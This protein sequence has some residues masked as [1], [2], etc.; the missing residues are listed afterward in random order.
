MF[1]N[2]CGKRICSH[3]LQLSLDMKYLKNALALRVS[4][5]EYGIGG[6]TLDFSLF[7]LDQQMDF[8]YRLLWVG[9]WVP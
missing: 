7:D 9:V 4:V 2:A 1:L 6:F 8:D 3:I 5:W